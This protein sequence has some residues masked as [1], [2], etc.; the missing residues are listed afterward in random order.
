MT[1]QE[2]YDKVKL[3]KK[4]EEDEYLQVRFSSKTGAGGYLTIK[5]QYINSNRWDVLSRAVE[6]LE[7]MSYYCG[8]EIEYYYEIQKNDL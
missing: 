4:I 5:A 8:N 2:L 1:I 3:T 7:K 6:I